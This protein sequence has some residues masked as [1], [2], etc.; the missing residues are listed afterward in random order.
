MDAVHLFVHQGLRIAVQLRLLFQKALLQQGAE[1][2]GPDVPGVPVGQ[3]GR[4]RKEQPYGN[5]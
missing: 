3:S 2:V 5:Y 4:R 1:V